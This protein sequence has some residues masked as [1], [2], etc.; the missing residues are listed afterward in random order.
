M[1]RAFVVYGGARAYR[2]AGVEYV[3]AAAFLRDLPERL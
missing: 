1:A 3:P 2:E